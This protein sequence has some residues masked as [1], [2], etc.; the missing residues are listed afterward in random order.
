MANLKISQLPA[1]APAQSTDLVAIARSGANFFLTVAQLIAAI[2]GNLSFSSLT[3]GINTVAAMVVGSGA[4]LQATGSGQIIA[5][6]ISPS[7]NAPQR[8]A[9]GS[10]ASL[11][12]N[13]QTTVISISVTFPSAAGTYRAL[14]SF[15]AWA[16]TGAN[17]IAAFVKDATNSR[18][19]AMAGQNANGSGFVGLSGSELSSATYA[20]GATVTFTLEV[21]ANAGATVTVNSGLFSLSPAEASFLSVT[22]VLSN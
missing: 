20:A 14:V 13:V 10:P 6:N 18:A 21:I 17:A 7:F 11:S 2:A 8:A 1:G 15:G 4:T 12:A 5:T 3:S 16:T 19:F 22:P 9:L